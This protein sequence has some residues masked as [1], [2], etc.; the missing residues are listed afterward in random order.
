MRI[1]TA[2]GILSVGILGTLLL[3]SNPDKLPVLNDTRPVEPVAESS[4][5][6]EANQVALKN[7]DIDKG[8]VLVLADEVNNKTADMIIDGIKDANHQKGSKP[9]YLLLDSPG[10]S[11]IDG[12]RII[13]AM[14]A[15]SRP[16][17]TVCMQICASM[18]A[19]I[20]EYGVQRYAVDRA[21]IMF[22]PA[23]VGVMFQGELDKLVSRYSFLKRFVDKMDAYTAMR[24][25][26]TYVEFK[27]KSTRELWL[28]SADALTGKYIDSIV[29]VDVNTKYN[30]NLGNNKARAKVEASWYN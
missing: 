8:V 28:D 23:S 14:Q 29:R 2:L 3:L 15:S 4:A 25:S 26:Q 18:A 6:P 13:S 11:V 30:L 7:L 12:A 22:H 19:M 24:S 1:V 10:G 16:V 27:S 5:V 9:I 20:L 17:Y 21:L